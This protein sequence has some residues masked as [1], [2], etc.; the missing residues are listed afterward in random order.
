MRGRDG[1][2][3]HDQEQ[4]VLWGDP[5]NPVTLT[6]AYDGSALPEWLL[7]DGSSMIFRAFYGVPQTNRAPDGTLINAVRG[8]LDRLASLV[9]ERKPLHVAVTTDEDWRPDWRC[10]LRPPHQA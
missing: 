3:G 1:R 7:V 4:R 5:Q 8:F 6:S 9:N 2:E 10:A